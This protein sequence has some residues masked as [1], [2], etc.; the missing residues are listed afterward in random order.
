MFFIVQKLQMQRK[1]RRKFNR[2]AKKKKAPNLYQVFFFASL[3]CIHTLK[4]RSCFLL[5]AIIG[6]LNSKWSFLLFL[7]P[8]LGSKS[9][10]TFRKESER[11]KEKKRE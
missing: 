3:W 6:M 5:P 2:F 11:I 1:S 8:K 9:V 7:V 4:V 10:Y